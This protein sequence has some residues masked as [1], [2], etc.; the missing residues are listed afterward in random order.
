MPDSI[1]TARSIKI[2]ALNDTLRKYGIGGRITQTQGFAFLDP[3][4]KSQFIQAI[5][6]N[7]SFDDD[8]DPYGEHD[9]GSKTICGIEV[10]WKIEYYDL[11]MKYQSE[12]PEDETVTQRVM[13]IMLA[14][15]Y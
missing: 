12:A 5:R 4:M 13:T 1:H 9:F 3:A 15:E 6:S 10:Y 14:D 11:T 7:E 2:A 8:D